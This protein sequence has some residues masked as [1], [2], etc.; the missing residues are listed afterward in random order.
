MINVSILASI[1]T[2]KF[3]CRNCLQFE[4][5]QAPLGTEG[6][7]NK[8]NCK[9]QHQGWDYEFPNSKQI[10][11]I[12]ISLAS[13]YL[14]FFFPRS[15]SFLSSWTP[16]IK[17]WRTARTP[18]TIMMMHRK[19]WTMRVVDID[20]AT[21][22]PVVSGTYSMNP[23]CRIVRASPQSSGKRVTAFRRIPSPAAMTLFAF[24]TSID[25]IPPRGRVSP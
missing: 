21:C 3:S 25:R 24:A 5:I 9:S 20:G 18:P 19:I 2:S 15:L 4:S 7:R 23:S 13:D 6:P 12:S 1:W 10:I 17:L 8:W 11:K 14:V 22:I 16:S